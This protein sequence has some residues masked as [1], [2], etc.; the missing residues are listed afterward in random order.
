[1]MLFVCYEWLL[2]TGNKW[3]LLI[4]YFADVLCLIHN[5]SHRIEISQPQQSL[6]TGQQQ[7]L[8]TSQQQALIKSLVTGQQAIFATWQ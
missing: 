8:A 5:I 1:M 7:P 6:A 2:L 4:R 3:L